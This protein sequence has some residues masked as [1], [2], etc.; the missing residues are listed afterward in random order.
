MVGVFPASEAEL[1]L[2]KTW[3]GPAR[4]TVGGKSTVR[5]TSSEEGGQTPL[6]IV[7]VN[8][9]APADSPE[10]E[11]DEFEGFAIIPEP[12]VKVQF[13]VPDIGLFPF[14]FVVVLQIF[15]SNPARAVLGSASIWMLT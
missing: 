1:A 11:E 9:F 13:P 2:H 10:T 7:Q 15:A 8:V 4:E 14:R 5:I 3:S 6:D 12:E